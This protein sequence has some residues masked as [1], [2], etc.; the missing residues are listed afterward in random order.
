M[1]F[2]LH[3]LVYAQYS[4]FIAN[5]FPEQSSGIHLACSDENEEE[6]VVYLTVST[7]G[8]ANSPSI[9]CLVTSCLAASPQYCLKKV[10]LLSSKMTVGL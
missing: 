5:T 9:S 3:N 6:E 1:I 8:Y 7:Q 10:S 4:S 2:V